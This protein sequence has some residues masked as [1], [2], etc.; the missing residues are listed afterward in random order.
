MYFIFSAV[1]IWKVDPGVNSLFDA[2][3]FCFA[4]VTTIGFGD[5]IITNPIARIAAMFLAAVGIVTLA[6][7]LGVIINFLNEIQKAKLDSST[8]HLLQDLHNLEDLSKSQLRKISDKIKKGQ[9]VPKV[10]KGN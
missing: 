8:L 3:W 10:D 9:E 5:I 4:V 2:V 1:V 7:V 6:F